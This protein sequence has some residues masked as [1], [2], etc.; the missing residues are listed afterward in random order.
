MRAS[1]SGFTLVEL[2][3]ALILFVIVGGAMY[4]LL[5]VAQRVSR[6]QTEK[7]TMQGGLRAG[8]QLAIAELQEIWSDDD[9]NESAI[10]SMS[11]TGIHYN[12]MRGIGVTCAPA[13]PTQLLLRSGPASY[14]GLVTPVPADGGNYDAYLFVDGVTDDEADD[15]WVNL[16]VSSGAPGVC[17]DGAA[18][19]QLTYADIGSVAGVGAIAP[20]RIHELMQIGQ[21]TADGRNW[22]GIGREGTGQDLTPLAGPLEATGV[23]FVYLDEDDNVTANTDEVRSIVMRLF[24]E[25]ERAA[26]VGSV[27]SQTRLLTDTVVVRVQLRNAR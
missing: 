24:G 22:L 3:V 8:V 10:T 18:A 2:L 27:S 17:T 25:T 12:A 15:T 9:A 21:V 26:N 11:A 6:T 16:N 1:R 23:D 4:S 20:V 19:I 14:A 13:T 5:N 7:A